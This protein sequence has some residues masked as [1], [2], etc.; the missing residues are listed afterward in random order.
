[1]LRLVLVL[2]GAFLPFVTQ[3]PASLSQMETE[4]T[5][6][7]DKPISSGDVINSTYLTITDHRYRYGDF[8]L[9][10]ITGTVVN[11]STEEVS[12]ITVTAALYDSSH[13]LVTTAEGYA[14]FS[15][16]PP[17]GNSP[18]SISLGVDEDI[19]HYTLFPGGT[20]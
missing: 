6:V 4:T 13:R 3:P 19:D 12:G 15:T 18:F 7:Q 1:M 11:N 8:F 14:D 2:L 9:D 10:Q 17:G 5:I 20:P 16:L